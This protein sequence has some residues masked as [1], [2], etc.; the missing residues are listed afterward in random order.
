MEKGLSLNPRAIWAY[1]NLVPAYIAAGKPAHAERGARAMLSAYPSLSLAAVAR[2][3]V[4]SRPTMA[5]ISDGL[6]RSGL[7]AV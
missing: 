7:P 6:Y 5:R 4:F 3:M 1:R 2:A